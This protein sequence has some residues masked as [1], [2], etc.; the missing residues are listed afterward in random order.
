MLRLGRRGIVLSLFINGL[1]I[2]LYLIILVAA[3]LNIVDAS[4]NFI[5]LNAF[6]ASFA[7]LLVISEI[8]LP[9]LTYEY[10]R[11]LC[12]YRGRGMTY[13]L[14]P[15]NLY[16]G[17]IVV[18]MGLAFFMLSYVK[19]IPPLD[20]LILNIKKLD[21][22]KEQKHFRVQLE[23]QRIFEQQLQQEQNLTRLIP[24]HHSNSMTAHVGSPKQLRAFSAT[25]TGSTNFSSPGAGAGV[26]VG[27]GSGTDTSTRAGGVGTNVFSPPSLSQRP[28][29]QPVF[30]SQASQQQQNRAD[31]GTAQLPPSGLQKKQQGS[32]SS[33]GSEQR[34]QRQP[35]DGQFQHQGPRNTSDTFNGRSMDR[36]ECAVQETRLPATQQPLQ[37]NKT[38][39]P[40]INTAELEGFPCPS[41]ALSPPRTRRGSAADSEPGSPLQYLIVDDPLESA[42]GANHGNKAEWDR[43]GE[44]ILKSAPH[45][46]KARH[47][48]L[49]METRTLG[50]QGV[51]IRVSIN[52]QNRQANLIPF[53]HFSPTVIPPQDQQLRL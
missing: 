8:R 17:I 20:G 26:G 25:N 9:Q 18:C 42:Q 30:P 7:C 35:H 23:A 14:T 5:I 34:P 27:V 10:F 12:T 33:I 3:C 13:L 44:S 31:Q 24:A 45:H 28:S 36:K 39:P 40:I 21:Q 22:W 11:F 53:I 38:L 46:V 37:L 32:T 15:F 49:P 16:G 47:R 51:H 48:W 1:N 50:Q 6:A 41:F 43:G 19:L 52:P 2:T 4:I 29:Y